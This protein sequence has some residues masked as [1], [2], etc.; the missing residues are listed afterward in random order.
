[1]FTVDARYE[2]SKRPKK[3]AQMRPYNIPQIIS[4]P[5]LYCAAVL[6][7]ILVM[8]TSGPVKSQQ[9]VGYVQ[10]IVKFLYPI[11][12]GYVLVRQLLAIYLRKFAI[13]PGLLC[14]I[15]LGS[16]AFPML[17][18]AYVN[19]FGGF[20]SGWENSPGLPS[21]TNIPIFWFAG[22]TSALL[23]EVCSLLYK[24]WDY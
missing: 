5:I 7:F 13:R 16:V 1:M 3:D 11:S 9:A 6:I 20:Y 22:M 21:Y 8:N 15:L 19:L 24:N 2:M 14:P 12:L 4:T 23:F 17:A 18:V 10:G